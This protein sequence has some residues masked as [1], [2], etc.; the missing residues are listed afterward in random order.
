MDIAQLPFNKLIG[1]KLADKN[2]GFLVYLPD[3]EQYTNHLGTVH[4]GALMSVA[5]AGSGAYSYCMHLAIMLDLSP[6]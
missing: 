5:E 1:L 4:G 2:S 6:S 3:I